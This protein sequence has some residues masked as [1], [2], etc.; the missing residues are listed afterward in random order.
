MLLYD[1]NILGKREL[2]MKKV[3]TK[4]SILEKAG[5][6]R[7]LLVLYDEK[8][9]LTSALQNKVEVSAESYYKARNCLEELGLIERY[10]LNLGKIKPYRLTERGKKIGKL[11]KK[12]EELVEEE[13]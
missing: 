8:E 1:L 10:N 11:L 13:I 6:A 2:I 3:Y 5:M 7:I 12:A 9:M 4:L